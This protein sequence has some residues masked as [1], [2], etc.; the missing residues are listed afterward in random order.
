MLTRGDFDRFVWLFLL[1]MAITLLSLPGHI[2]LFHIRSGRLL[3]PG[4]CESWL[5]VSRVEEERQKREGEKSN[6][7]T[8]RVQDVGATRRQLKFSCG[9]GH[10]GQ[11]VR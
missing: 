10:S 1:M 4:S 5:L 7:W 8:Y 2:V 9:A 3:R 11:R 6:F